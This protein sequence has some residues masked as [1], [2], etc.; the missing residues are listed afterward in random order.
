[1]LFAAA[2]AL[3]LSLPKLLL[4][5]ASFATRGFRDVCVFSIQRHLSSRLSLSRGNLFSTASLAQTAVHLILTAVVVIWVLALVVAAAVERVPFEDC[6]IEI[7]S[8]VM[9]RK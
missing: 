8:S 1:M 2:F 9:K 5:R 6:E 3:G 7:V 4:L